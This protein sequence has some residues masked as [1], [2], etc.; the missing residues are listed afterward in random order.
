MTA[1]SRAISYYRT[2]WIYALG[3]GGLYWQEKRSTKILDIDMDME[4]KRRRKKRKKSISAMGLCSGKAPFWSW[5]ENYKLP[6]FQ[7]PWMVVQP[8]HSFLKKE[9]SCMACWHIAKLSSETLNLLD[10]IKTNIFL[11]SFTV[12]LST[13]KYKG[14]VVA[15]LT[16]E[17]SFLVLPTY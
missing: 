13:P 2:C 16:F 9:R 8:Q 11:Q 10:Q 7:V 4:K 1:L 6:H 3:L 17:R 14:K 5:L 15:I 12:I